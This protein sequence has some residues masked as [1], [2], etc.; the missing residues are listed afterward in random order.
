MGFQQSE[1]CY[2]EV[3]FGHGCSLNSIGDNNIRA[4]EPELNLNTQKLET[5][6]SRLETRRLD[7]K[8]RKKL[9]N[10][11]VTRTWNME[12]SNKGVLKGGQWGMW[13]VD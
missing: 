7:S 9:K 8:Q 1:M 13:T 11:K 5:R 12:P 4:S 3:D 10:K 6:N 2:Y